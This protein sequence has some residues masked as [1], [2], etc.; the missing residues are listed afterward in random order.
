MAN[1]V[2]HTS[3]SPAVI[4][5]LVE[6]GV[7]DRETAVKSQE[8]PFCLNSPASSCFN[9]W[10]LIKPDAVSLTPDDV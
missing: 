1:P 10:H 2:S 7:S 9:V 4:M 3:H 8:V 5:S 6:K